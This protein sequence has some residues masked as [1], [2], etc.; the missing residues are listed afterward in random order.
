MRSRLVLA[1]RALVLAALVWAIYVGFSR[2]G[3][4]FAVFR[5]AGKLALEGRWE[6]LYAEGPDRFLYAPGFAFLVSPLA[7]LP[8]K[9]ALGVWLCLTLAAFG[10]AMRTLARATGEVPVLL[11]ILFSV[12]PLLIDLRYGQ[13]NL[14]ILSSAVWALLAWSER[15]G[16]RAAK[17]NLAASWF[18]FAIA[19]CAK[20]YPLAL[21]LY[22]IG[23]ML[24]DG[25]TGREHG[26]PAILGAIGGAA[27]LLLPPLVHS[28]VYA[29][30]MDALARKGL[31]T[32]T[33]NQS[34][35]AFLV[36]V[37]GGE[38]FYALGMG[39]E[40]LRFPG[41]PLSIAATK[42]IWIAFTLAVVGSIARLAFRRSGGF[43]DARLSAWLGLALCFV[44]AHLVWKSYFVLGIPLIAAIFASAKDDPAFRRKLAPTAVLLGLALACASIDVLGPRA[45][46]WV[47]ACA[48]FLWVHL[49]AIVTGFSRLSS[50][51]PKPRSA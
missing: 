28:G 42:A 37:V 16:T 40:A 3:Q 6:S 23:G 34:L 4:D 49:V 27:F 35:L 19:A 50:R 22:P 10:A 29:G 13:V 24:R 47:E 5:F 48:P 21:F 8:A 12:R 33:H 46:A 11:A 51:E 9:V 32:D 1:L 14:L 26:R 36:R 39:G 43:G 31:P 18:V 25:A 38:P 15:T 30:W 2:G 44:P 17:M 7:A 41:M 20:I 45:S